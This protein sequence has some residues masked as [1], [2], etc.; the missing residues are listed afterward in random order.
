MFSFIKYIKPEWYFILPVKKGKNKIVYFPDY[1]TLPTSIKDQLSIDEEYESNEAIKWDLAFQ[2]HLKG[3]LDLNTHNV[4]EL[5]RCESI[6]ISDNYRF[7]NRYFNK[8]WALYI[9][10]LRI[11]T[12]HNPYKE[13]LAWLKNRK[14]APVKIS[15]NKSVPQFQN[16]TINQNHKV[17]V[18]L[19]TLNRYEY[20]N[21]ALKALETQTYP[22]FEVIVIDQ[23]DDF[24]EHFYNQFNLPLVVIRQ[25]IK[26]QWYARNKGVRIAQGN[27]IAFYEDDVLIEDDWLENHMKC[28]CL[29][30]ADI[31]AG[32][33]IR[34]DQIQSSNLNFTYAYQFP[35]GNALVKREVFESIGIFDNQFNL[36]RWGDGDF[37][38]RCY[39]AGFKSIHNPLSTCI[40]LKATKGG[41][42]ESGSW[43]G[44]KPIYFFG[45]RPTPSVF[46]FHLKYFDCST[47]I[48][49][50]LLRIPLS[51]TNYKSITQNYIIGSL[52]C[53]LLLPYIILSITISYIKG[54]I[55]LKEGDKIEYL[56]HY[57]QVKKDMD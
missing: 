20:L 53:L 16:Q 32:R 1:D 21:K 2:F 30:N 24:K 3:I 17:S 43:D 41:L 37:G 27:Y 12:F 8:Y 25:K 6:S 13:I 18:I 44:Y 22:I 45:T 50:L 39:L 42:R 33:L 7:V 49:S 4:R 11:I 52:I 15:I 36:M 19:P 34:D 46:Y 23:S 57:E 38:L 29:F 54:Y 10:I 47:L 56:S 35:S 48:P 14:V 5:K 26:G 40:D 9:L 55:M 31:S 51:F 28:L